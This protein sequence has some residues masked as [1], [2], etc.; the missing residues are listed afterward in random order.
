MHINEILFGNLLG[1]SASSMQNSL[2]VFAMVLI[3]ILLFF[4]RFFTV[5]FDEVKLWKNR[6]KTRRF[7]IKFSRF[8][9]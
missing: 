1:V 2:V 5:F 9:S 7:R 6:L 3:V 8:F 4:R